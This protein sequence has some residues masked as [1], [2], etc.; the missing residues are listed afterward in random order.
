MLILKMLIWN[1]L[2]KDFF[3]DYKTFA[4]IAM[5]ILVSY[6]ERLIATGGEFQ[7]EYSKYVKSL[8]RYRNILYMNRLPIP[9]PLISRFCCFVSR[10]LADHMEESDPEKETAVLLSVYPATRSF[11]KEKYTGPREVSS[12]GEVDGQKIIKTSATLRVYTSPTLYVPYLCSAYIPS[13]MLTT[14]VTCDAKCC[15]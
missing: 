7:R 13:S 2:K 3:L 15:V 5:R 14:N 6:M 11:A 1:R 12:F 10:L 9:I 8:Y 4:D